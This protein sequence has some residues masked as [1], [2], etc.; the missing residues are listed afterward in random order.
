MREVNRFIRGPIPSGD[1]LGSVVAVRGRVGLALVA[2]AAAAATAAAVGRDLGGLGHVGPSPDGLHEVSKRR[3]PN[4]M[5]KQN[6]KG[7][8]PH[9][10]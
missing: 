3:R 1:R 5:A 8:K 7:I 6:D 9:Q 4:A 2:T 10:T